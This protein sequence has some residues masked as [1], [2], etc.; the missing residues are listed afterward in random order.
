MFTDCPRIC[1]EFARRGSCRFRN[2][3]FSHDVAE[4][5]LTSASKPSQKHPKTQ[6]TSSERGFR[7]WRKDIPRDTH[8]TRPL[9]HRLGWFF[10]KAR[11]LIDQG[12]GVLQDVVRALSQEGGLKRIQE[13]VERDFDLFSASANSAVFEA[14]VLPF[15][16]IITHPNV[17]AS[18]ILEQAVGTIYNFLF[19]IFGKRGVRF[20]A[21]LVS[22]LQNTESHESTTASYF[23]LCLHVLW[24]IIDLNSTAF[25]LEPFKPLAIKLQQIFFV[26]LSSDS[27]S[28][29]YRAR[30][31]LERILRRLNIGSSLPGAQTSTVVQ[32]N[33]R[34]TTTP[35]VIHRQQP[36]GR[37]NNDSADI[38]VIQIMPT[39]EEILSSRSEYLPVKDPGRWHIGGVSGLLDRNFRLL[40]ED[41]VGQLRD[42]I[43]AL[44]KP[45]NPNR[46][47]QENQVRTYV[48]DNVRVAQIH[49]DRLA[50][51]QFVVQFRQPENVRKMAKGQREEWWE[52][53]KRLQCGALICLLLSNQRAIFC[54]IARP[55]RPR[56]DEFGNTHQL[57]N[58]GLFLR[59]RARQLLP[60][61]WFNLQTTMCSPSS[62]S[63]NLER[64]LPPTRWWSSQVSFW[65]ALS[66]LFE[67]CKG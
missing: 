42:T 56:R 13:L 46:V 59:R 51:L 1:R 66:P 32:K 35:F 50:G 52:Q 31:H 4:T 34:P 57:K 19:G 21:F 7:A 20:V 8:H 49:F 26:L 38:C 9:G 44:L 67:R 55:P 27:A 24:Q 33:H 6:P 29:L 11:R 16:Q 63:I 54:T 37:H 60:W 48:H 40:R 28:S 23:E 47:A 43:H 64:T 5:S 39:S 65:Q 2:C 25:A 61:N 53:S 3:K 45:S 30:T 14:Q 15:L 12:D 41:T 36:G 58:W 22:V 10:K 62:T 17:L 18:L